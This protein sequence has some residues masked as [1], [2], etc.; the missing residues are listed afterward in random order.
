MS[1]RTRVKICGIRDFDAAL[2]AIEAGAD[3][4]GLVFVE[5]SPRH[6]DVGR[7]AQ[8]AASLPPFVQSVVL[9]A[10]M[11]PGRVLRLAEE[12]AASWVQ[13]HGLE[14]E[15]QVAQLEL[16]LIRGFRFSPEAVRRWNACEMVDALLIDGSS[17]G[18]GTSFDWTQLA[19]MM[20]EIDKPVILAGGLT[21]ENV[22]EA[23]ETI[24]PWAVDVSSG[25]E[26]RR[27]VKDEDLI[28]A[29]CEAVR[30]ADGG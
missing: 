5:S 6:V 2:W 17:G 29:F 18:E 28:H 21:P 11:A 24:R 16:P 12:V 8:I 30:A 3:A 26:R 10:D 27:G 14:S 7:A 22:G 19:D 9:T 15:G 1:M 13:V 20:D 4:I 23:I 25:V